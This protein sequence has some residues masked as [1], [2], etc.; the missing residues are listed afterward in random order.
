MGQDQYDGDTSKGVIFYGY[1]LEESSF[2]TSYI[3]NHGTSGGA[4]RIKDDV[5]RLEGLNADGLTNGYNTTIYCKFKMIY[6]AK[7]ASG[8]LVNFTPNVSGSLASDPRMLLFT[9]PRER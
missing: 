1:Q 3:P 7:S 4:T 9:S 6:D 8:F 2:A 5:D